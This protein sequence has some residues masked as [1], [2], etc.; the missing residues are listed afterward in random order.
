MQRLGWCGLG[1]AIMTRRWVGGRRRILSDLQETAPGG[2]AGPAPEADDLA[3]EPVE[4]SPN[5]EP[6][7]GDS[8][9]IKDSRPDMHDR[10]AGAPSGEDSGR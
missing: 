1:R 3:P 9:T 8:D 5:T 10:D 7:S 4:T 6:V 2:E